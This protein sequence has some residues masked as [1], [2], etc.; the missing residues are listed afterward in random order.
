M[1]YYVNFTSDITFLSQSTST[2]EGT[3][4]N[5]GCNSIQS[6]QLTTL[7]FQGDELGKLKEGEKSQKLFVIDFKLPLN[8]ELS[9][10]ELNYSD[11]QITTQVSDNSFNLSVLT[12][13]NG[14]FCLCVQYTG[15]FWEEESVNTKRRVE[16]GVF[17]MHNCH[18]IHCQ[19]P[20]TREGGLES[21]LICVSPLQ[22][23]FIDCNNL[24]LVYAPG[25][26][27]HVLN[28][29]SEFELYH[30]IV[31]VGGS[32]P[33]FPGGKEQPMEVLEG[34]SGYNW[35][36]TPND[37]VIYRVRFTSVGLLQ[38]FEQTSCNQNM[39]GIIHIAL[40]YVRFPELITGIF[41]ILTQ[42]SQDL[43]VKDVY[44]EYLLALPYAEIRST[45]PNKIRRYLP[46]TGVSAF[47]HRENYK[48]FDKIIASFVTNRIGKV[49]A[50]IFKIPEGVCHLLDIVKNNFYL[51]RYG[52]PRFN[53][54]NILQGYLNGDGSILKIHNLIQQ[55]QSGMMK[56]K[57][58]FSF[59]NFSRNSS[60]QSSPITPTLSGDEQMVPYLDR[61]GLKEEGQG[62]L[63]MAQVLWQKLFQGLSTYIAVR[64]GEESV[65]KIIMRYVK[66]LHEAS[67]KLLKCILNS[68]NIQPDEDPLL[69]PMGAQPTSISSRLH[70]SL[71]K[72]YTTVREL[73][74]TLP[75][76]FDSTYACLAVR[77]LTP[78][79]FIRFTE[80][81]LI[82]LTDYFMSK[83]ERDHLKHHNTPLYRQIA[84]LRESRLSAD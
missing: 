38:M 65:E 46:I 37:S 82:T 71:E 35:V 2:T 25:L 73:S 7:Y 13:D 41:S 45:L 11:R 48:E 77:H 30:H 19:V 55:Q 56:K 39:L 5:T 61:D 52:R 29:S 40:L 66:L 51:Y 49:Y 81:E 80:Q 3:N 9:F 27:L 53:P 18:S 21:P 15:L 68:Y 6:L 1:L 62:N 26:F 17:M 83:M 76:G 78:Q 14:T 28:C 24:I 33:P 16:Y 10:R 8:Y 32:C 58:F 74:Y 42:R 67:C 44:T 79:V 31:A 70:C 4:D 36:L 43:L 75:K 34:R 59:L 22:L 54:K 84:S 20:V 57:G 23:Q 12:L 47:Y 50:E 69:V 63:L 72:Y 64:D 60:N